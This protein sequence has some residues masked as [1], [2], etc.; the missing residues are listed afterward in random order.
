MIDD[1]GDVGDN[2]HIPDSVE[3]LTGLW[4]AIIDNTEEILLDSD[5]IR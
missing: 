3:I 4:R 5:R 2:S 1:S